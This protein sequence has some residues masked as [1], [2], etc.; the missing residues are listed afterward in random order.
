MLKVGI[1]GDKAYGEFSATVVPPDGPLHFLVTGKKGESLVLPKDQPP[2]AK[3]AQN[4][5]EIRSVEFRRDRREIENQFADMKDWHR[6]GSQLSP[7]TKLNLDLE[8]AIIAHVQNLRR[9]STA[10]PAACSSDPPQSTN[11][12]Y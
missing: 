6:F 2:V 5:T 9:E 11:P 8:T 12:I 7:G 10:A 3:A 4:W 1:C